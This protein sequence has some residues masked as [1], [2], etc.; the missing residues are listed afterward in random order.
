[1]GFLGTQAG[2]PADVNLILQIAILCAL[3]VGR[4][5][6]KRKNFRQHGTIMAVAL[7]LNAA[8]LAT[9]MLPSLLLGL[10]FVVAN[11]ENPLSIIAIL[12]AGL[13]T[14]SLFLGIYLV[15]TWRFSKPLVACLKNRR[16]MK[17]TIILWTTT[18]IIGILL[19]LEL[20]V[21]FRAF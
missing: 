13:G 4:S 8:S 11:P 3:L 5:R 2:I 6:A 1:M 15:M 19:Y 17:P 7:T 16:L 14:V 10:G 12:H 20:Y 18:A 21:F 9:I